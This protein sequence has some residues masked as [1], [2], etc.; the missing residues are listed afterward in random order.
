VTAVI[1]AKGDKMN[2]SITEQ[3]GTAQGTSTGDQPKANKKASL[4]RQHAH[5]RPKKAKSAKN[6]DEAYARSELF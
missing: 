1:T 3:T 4:A 6:D 2:T 5:V